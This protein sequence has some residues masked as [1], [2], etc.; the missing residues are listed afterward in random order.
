MNLSFIS[1][2]IWWMKP[3]KEIKIEN[4]CHHTSKC[5]MK[6]AE[7]LAPPAQH[8]LSKTVSLGGPRGKT[9]E[10]KVTALNGSA[11]N[12]FSSTPLSLCQEPKYFPQASLSVIS[13]NPAASASQAGNKRSL[14][15][16]ESICSWS[17]Q[18]SPKSI[19]RMLNS[20]VLCLFHSPLPLFISSTHPPAV[21]LPH[22]LTW[23]PPGKQVTSGGW[24]EGRAHVS[25]GSVKHD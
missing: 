7:V 6:E 17:T 20:V 19:K 2:N 10:K 11:V 12:L 25:Q 4:I 3:A 18:R 15:S 9:K 22:S 1:C 13:P 16:S 21:A 5:C 8:T 23:G 14:V 24:R